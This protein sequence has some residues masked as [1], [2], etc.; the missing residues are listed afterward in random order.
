VRGRRAWAA[1]ANPIL[2]REV[3]TRMRGG[4]APLTVTVFLTLVGLAGYS[5]YSTAVANSN[6]PALLTT[7]GAGLFLNMAAAV[8]ALVVLLS[9]GICASTIT[10]ERERQT[11]DLLLVTR[12]HARSIVIGKLFSS[13]LFVF[14]LIAASL[15]LFSIV[16]LLGGIRLRDVAV[17]A[18][19]AATLTVL[20]GSVGMFFSAL[21]RRTPAATLATY[22][23]V[24][25]LVAAPGLAL[26]AAQR[27]STTNVFAAAAPYNCGGGFSGYL[28]P[29]IGGSSGLVA[30]Q[31]APPGATTVLTGLL[32]PWTATAGVLEPVISRANGGNNC[33]PAT[34]FGLPGNCLGPNT[35]TQSGTIASGALF[36][37]WPIWAAALLVDAI[38]AALLLTGSVLLLR[39]RLP[40]P[41][42]DR[43]VLPRA[44]P[45]PPE[46]AT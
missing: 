16:F 27:G 2:V 41:S 46:P 10:S 17:V 42:R 13:L 20:L 31:P 28:G 23:L 40:R 15:P 35:A 8:F 7:A 29:G 30:C 43:G 44:T 25:I 45:A 34:G 39:R 22:V 26:A 6:S 18:V 1:L 24:F 4:R 32:S 3:R 38:V 21:L 19:F 37:G 14:L 9:P 33:G 12:M 11:L 5:T 36:G